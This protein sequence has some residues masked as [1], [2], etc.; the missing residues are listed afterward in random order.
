MILL[1]LAVEILVGVGVVMALSL[2][3]EYASLKLAGILAGVPTGSA[4]ILFFIGIENGASFASKTAVF[5][6]IGLLAMQSFLFAYYKASNRFKTHTIVLSALSALAVYLLVAYAIDL[7]EM[8]IVMAAIVSLISIFAFYYLYRNIKDARIKSRIRLTPDVMALRGI[9]AAAIIVGVIEI[10]AFVGPAWA[11][12]LAAFPTTTFPLI[13]IIHRTY[14][15]KPV[16]TIIKN[17]QVGLGSV[18]AY[19]LTVSLAYPVAGIWY[20]TAMALA[21]ALAAC[22]VIYLLLRYGKRIKH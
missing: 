9:A 19:A 14:G 1:L 8:G 6:L 11:G 10:A 7:I 17:F 12:L 21:A 20:G 2:V 3:G 15:K 4:I 16:H 18:I 5:N 22:F 13:L